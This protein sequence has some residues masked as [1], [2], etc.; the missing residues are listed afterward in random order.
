LNFFQECEATVESLEAIKSM[1]VDLVIFDTSMNGKNGINVADQIRTKYPLRSI[2]TLCIENEKDNKSEIKES[3]R[4]HDLTSRN[5]VSEI[6]QALDYADSL[7]RCQ[8]SGF[9]ISL[10]G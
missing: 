9:T 1:E 8:I 10:D 3:I 6:S 7:L 2:I 5:L 4:R